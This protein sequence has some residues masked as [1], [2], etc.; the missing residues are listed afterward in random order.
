MKREIFYKTQHME[1][2]SK[3]HWEN[4][5]AQNTCR[6]KVNSKK[7]RKGLKPAYHTACYHQI[8]EQ[9]NLHADP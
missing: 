5:Q 2:V 4:L 8:Q 6:K 1:R 7:L 9:V 3:T